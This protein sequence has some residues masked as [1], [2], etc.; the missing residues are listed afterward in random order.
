MV[1]GTGA[2]RGYAF[3]TLLDAADSRAHHVNAGVRGSTIDAQLLMLDRWLDAA[4]PQRVVLHVFAANDLHELDRRSICC[5]LGPL[6][7]SEPPYR[8]RC[9]APA[10]RLPLAERV[11]LS[12]APYVVRATAPSSALA[13]RVVHGLAVLGERL[14]GSG[15]LGPRLDSLPARNDEVA[16]ARYE[17]LVRALAERARGAGAGLTFVLLASRMTLERSLGR[18]PHAVDLWGTLDEGERAHARL[19]ALLQRVANEHQAKVIDTR[20]FFLTLLRDPS[21]DEWFARDTPGDFHLS[22][23]G[24]RRFADWLAPMLEAP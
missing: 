14:A 24:H 3:P 19:R 13:T 6:V 17:A 1:E 8:G 9:A 12:P 4:H 21:P 18:E 5:G 11:K 22:R 23:A 10:W 16:F 2:G 7:T 20:E 15:A